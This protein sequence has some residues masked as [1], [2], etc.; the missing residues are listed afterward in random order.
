MRA[1]CQL[2]QDDAHIA[3]HRQQHLAKGLGLVF[4]SGVEFELFELRQTV[5]Q[6]GHRCAK[7]LDQLGFGD[8]AVFNRVVQQGGHQ[9]LRIELP[10]GALL[11]HS[12]RVRDV[13][14]AAVA[15][16]AEVRLVSVAVRAPDL[17]YVGCA[18]VL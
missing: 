5:D 9:R 18:Q 15:K 10:F 4:F 14:L 3:G 2:D 12:D 7:A 6:L 1:I 8:T 16:L 17:V 11:G 13:G